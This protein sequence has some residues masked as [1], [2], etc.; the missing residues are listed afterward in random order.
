M[1]CVIVAGWLMGNLMRMTL[2]AIAAVFVSLV[3]GIF[4][5]DDT[6]LGSGWSRA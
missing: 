6:I 4:I 5:L 3:V 1:R 2:F